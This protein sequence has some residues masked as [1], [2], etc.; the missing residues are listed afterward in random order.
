[1]NEKYILKEVE[2]VTAIAKNIFGDIV[3]KVYYAMAYYET[4]DEQASISHF[5]YEIENSFHT[6]NSIDQD[7]MTIVIEFTNGKKVVFSNSEWGSMESFH[8][9]EIEKFI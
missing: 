5:N 6:A 1:M 3:E 8:S 4:M 7:C 9:D 2:K